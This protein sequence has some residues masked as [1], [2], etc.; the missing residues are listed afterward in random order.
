MR[1]K[2]SFREPLNTDS[3]GLYITVGQM[4]FFLNR[5]D[6]QKNFSQ[7]SDEFHD[8]YTKCSI[9]NLI[10]DLM[11]ENPDCAMM[12]WDKDQMCI[13]FPADGYV[14][15]ELERRNIEYKF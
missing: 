1:N 9:Y 8:Y 13:K 11:D 10:Y 3:E 4:Q 14:V 7:D 2:F 15:E 5:P 12:Y 6:G